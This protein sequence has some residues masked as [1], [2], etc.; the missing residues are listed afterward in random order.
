MVRRGLRRGWKELLRM[1]GF[2]KQLPPDD[3][4]KD[5]LYIGDDGYF[6]YKDIPENK[7][8]ILRS[9]GKH[10]G[11]LCKVPKIRYNGEQYQLHRLMYWF[12][13]GKWPDYINQ[14]DGDLSNYHFDNLRELPIQ[15][16]K[17]ISPKSGLSVA[18]QRKADGSYKYISC[19]NIDGK[20]T[21]LG[22]YPDEQSALFMAWKI[23]DLLYPG[24]VPIPDKIKHIVAISKSNIEVVN[25]STQ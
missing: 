12:V 8:R 4:I 24:L 21:Y 1:K 6:H 25:K 5:V 7:N 18:P 14:I 15:A 19:I 22:S 17:V 11:Y 2:K 16:L 9:K 13:T 23:R 10:A 3:G 20:P